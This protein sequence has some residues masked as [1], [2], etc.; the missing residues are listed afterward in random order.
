MPWF[1]FL[2]VQVWSYVLI[3]PLFV[4]PQVPPVQPMGAVGVPPPGFSGPMNIPPPSFPPGVPPPPGPFI[5]PG[6]NPMQMPP[7]TTTLVTIKV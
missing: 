1:L 7:G 5:R 2:K 4:R 6:F 3:F